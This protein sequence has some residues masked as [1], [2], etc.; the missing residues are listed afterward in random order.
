MRISEVY[1]VVSG[2]ARY[3]RTHTWVDTY[4]RHKVVDRNI[5]LYIYFVLHVAI[6]MVFPLSYD[7]IYA[8][9]IYLV[10]TCGM[11]VA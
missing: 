1:V 2:E 8:S 7:T 4:A 3:V 9:I 6:I 5:C 11:G 10:R